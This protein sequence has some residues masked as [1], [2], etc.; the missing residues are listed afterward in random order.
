MRVVETV[1][2]KWHY[3]IDRKE[4]CWGPTSLRDLSWMGHCPTAV[5]SLGSEQREVFVWKV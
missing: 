1:E 4:P 2:G 5:S 3:Q